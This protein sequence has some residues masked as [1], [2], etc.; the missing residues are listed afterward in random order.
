MSEVHDKPTEAE[1]AAERSRVM[2][3]IINVDHV[4]FSVKLLTKWA[5]LSLESRA[6]LHDA[7]QV[8]ANDQQLYLDGKVRG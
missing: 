2:R 3:P 5:D 8:F 1:R 6:R 4:V 7:F